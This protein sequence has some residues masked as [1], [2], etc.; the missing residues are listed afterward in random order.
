MTVTAFQ[1][2]LNAR[3][4]LPNIIHVFSASVCYHCDNVV[5]NISDCT[6]TKVCGQDQ[7]SVS[8]ILCSFDMRLS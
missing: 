3:N 1:G 6:T 4:E 7:V 8:R 2:G 5:A